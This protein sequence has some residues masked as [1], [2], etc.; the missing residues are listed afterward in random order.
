MKTS[1]LT[2]AAAGLMA[3][4][5]TASGQNPPAS[6]GQAQQPAQGI[7]RGGAP[8]AWGDKNKD[9]ICDITGRP[10]GQGRGQGAG[11]RMGRGRGQ[12]SGG[13]CNCCG[14]NQ[15]P[16]AAPQPKK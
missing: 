3:F 9:G 16:A 6:S 10:V 7:G 14:Q 13:R 4:G 8:H 15:T 12:M 1:L 2:I 11:R 5:L